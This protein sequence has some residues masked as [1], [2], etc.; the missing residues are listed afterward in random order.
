MKLI[1]VSLFALA[2]LSACS[3]GMPSNVAVGIGGGNHNFGLGT[4]IYFP[5]KTKSVPSDPPVIAGTEQSNQPAAKLSSQKKEA[6]TRL[7]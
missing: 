1:P 6:A 2:L 5:I 4:S 3:V 7:K